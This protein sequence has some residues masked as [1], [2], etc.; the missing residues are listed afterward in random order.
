MNNSILL[1]AAILGL[2]GLFLTGQTA[3]AQS[4]TGTATFYVTIN[5]CP[6][7]VKA[8]AILQG[9]YNGTTMAINNSFRNTIPLQQPY[10]VSPW[11]YSGTESLGTLPANAID[12]VLLEV[13]T[14]P[15]DAAIE[16]KAA[17]LLDNGQIKDV[18]GVTDGVNFYALTANQP[19][20]LIV[21]HRNHIALISAES[22][23][24]PNTTYFDFSV[25]NNV[26][27]GAGQ[28]AA[29]PNATYGL[30]VGD[31]DGNGLIIVNDLNGFSSETSII[32]QYRSGDFQ[33]NGSVTVSDFNLYMPNASKIGVSAI[34]Y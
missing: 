13:R 7:V 4:C 9:P 28:L 29:L 33:M 22:V 23:S 20:Y 16:R 25:P 18:D 6:V 14:S 34:R 30:N 8:K 3:I 31:W 10:N 11:N 26:M 1:I 2:S 17:I 5:N 19:Y 32:N 24:L 12:W 27:G 21:R 15:N